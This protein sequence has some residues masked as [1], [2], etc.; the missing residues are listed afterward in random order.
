[1]QIKTHFCDE[2]FAYLAHFYDELFAYHAHFYDKQIK[3][4]SEMP[5]PLIDNRYV[6]DLLNLC[7]EG[8]VHLAVT[9]NE[10]LTI[11]NALNSLSTYLGVVDS[12][13]V[14]FGEC[15]S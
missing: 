3:R 8:I 15:D 7:A 2:L 1:M 6:A 5:V 10:Q 13:R 14:F 4:T 12:G 11:H 9:L